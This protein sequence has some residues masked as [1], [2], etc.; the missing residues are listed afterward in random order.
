SSMRALAAIRRSRGP[1][2][3]PAHIDGVDCPR[4]RGSLRPRLM[5][6]RN[7]L[8]PFDPSHQ[9]LEL[10]RRLG[11]KIGVVHSTKLFGNGKQGLVSQADNLFLCVLLGHGHVGSASPRN[12]SPGRLPKA[13]NADA[14]RKVPVAS[15][16][17]RED[18]PS[19]ACLSASRRS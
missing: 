4:P 12:A 17:W 8:A 16:L 1:W 7:V 13:P 14:G 3:T 9:P 5:A 10:F 19:Q 15:S 18:Y 6:S 11:A 2:K